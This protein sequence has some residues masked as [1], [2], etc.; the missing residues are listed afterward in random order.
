MN[1]RKEDFLALI[2]CWSRSEY[3]YVRLFCFVILVLNIILMDFIAK[4]GKPSS[5]NGN[6]TSFFDMKTSF[7]DAVALLGISSKLSSTSKQYK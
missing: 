3:F 7:F 2:G 1:L 4:T 5:N 6:L